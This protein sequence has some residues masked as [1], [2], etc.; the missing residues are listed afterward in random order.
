MPKKV[1]AGAARLFH[2]KTA[3]KVIGFFGGTLG[4]GATFGSRFTLAYFGFAVAAIWAIGGWLTSETLRRRAPKSNT[5]YSLSTGQPRTVK[6]GGSEYF[7][8]WQIVPVLCIGI[9]FGVSFLWVRGI[10]WNQEQEDVYQS[11]SV[12][13]PV[14]KE[15]NDIEVSI[16]NGSKQEVRLD[17]LACKVVSATFAK[18]VI[19]NHNQFNVGPEL[20]ESGGDSESVACFKHGIYIN[21]RPSCIDLLVTAT[22]A[23]SDQ[24]GSIRSKQF[25]YWGLPDGGSLR[26]R[27]ASRRSSD[28]CVS[29]EQPIYRE[30]NRLFHEHELVK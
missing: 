30:R 11:L 13:T 12:Q 22:Y 6:Q 3:N 17:M 24:P 16:S 20:L 27:L 1:F 23:L 14:F 9:L 26:W 7:L 10:K 5:V 8:A 28:H 15:L 2:H 19:T 18:T 4:V 25:R 29:Q 21:E